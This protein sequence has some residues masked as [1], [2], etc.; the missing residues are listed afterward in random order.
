M[1]QDPKIVVAIDVGTSKVCTIIARK[2]DRRGFQILSHSVVPSRGIEKGNVTD[3]AA[4]RGA[5]A[6]SVAEAAKHAGVTVKEAYVGVTGSHISYQ[7]RHDQLRWANSRGVITTDELLQVPNTVAASSRQDGRRVLHALPRNYMLDGQRGIRN[8][9]GMHT[10]RLEVES[11]VVLGANELVEKLMY[12]VEQAGLNVV[13]LVLV[14]LA[15]AQAVLT[16]EEK[17]QGV[18]LVDLGGGTTDL[19][20]YSQGT[21]SFNAALPIGGFQFT[22]DICVAYG[23]TYEAAEEAKLE[24]GNTEPSAVQ[25]KDELSLPIEGR[26][27][28]RQVSLREICQ[29]M[30]ERAQELVRLVRIK[31]H[32]AGQSENS[33]LR[34]VLTGGASVLPGLDDMMRRAISRHVRIG[35]PNGV[36]DMPDELRSTKYATSVGLVLWA[37]KAGADPQPNAEKIG[38]ELETSLSGGVSK[39]FKR[40]LP[41]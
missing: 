7:N 26:T 4:T 20:V 41:R 30:R 10:S 15:S 25:A 37:M 27:T 8:P 38:P 28:H 3:V 12:A 2:E 33:D 16:E 21:V 6:A 13:S 31:L 1:M 29:L 17:E 35:L 23:T 18:A 32:E 36:L 22:N 39:I 34:L 14:P 9:L 24:F 40:W 11:H 5:I 19:V